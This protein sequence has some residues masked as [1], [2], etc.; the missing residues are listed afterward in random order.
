MG[1]DRCAVEGKKFDSPKRR[2]NYNIHS[3]ITSIKSRSLYEQVVRYAGQEAA[4]RD[5]E[6]CRRII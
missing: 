2:A 1:I 6:L 5:N 3:R 4:R